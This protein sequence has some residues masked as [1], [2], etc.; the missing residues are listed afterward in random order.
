MIFL[1]RNKTEKPRWLRFIFACVLG[2]AIYLTLSLLTAKWIL[3]GALPETTAQI[4]L[5][6]SAAI[7][8]FASGAVAAAGRGERRALHGLLAGIAVAV[9]VL[10]I[11][12]IC[13]QNAEW[14]Q[15]TAIA[16]ASC[17]VCGTLSSCIFHKRN[18]KATRSRKRKTHSK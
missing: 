15:Y 18:K 3:S 5:C 8:A 7:A 9:F 6:V 10:L 1:K 2:L 13:N 17:V 16:V 11:K 12:G 14:T 4:A